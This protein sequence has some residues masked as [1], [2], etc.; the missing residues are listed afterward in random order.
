MGFGKADSK[1]GK[2]M[3]FAVGFIT[4]FIIAIFSAAFALDYYM[5]KQEVGYGDK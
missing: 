4:G 1:G 3:Q 5:D 2:M